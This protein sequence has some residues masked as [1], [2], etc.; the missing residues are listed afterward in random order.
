M[1][2]QALRPRSVRRWLDLWI[3]HSL[4]DRVPTIVYSMERS[5]SVALFDSLQTCGDFAIVTHYLD[6]AKVADGLLSG[7]AVWA[8]RQLIGRGERA[9]VISLVRSPVDNMASTFARFEFGE[10]RS[11]HLTEPGTGSPVGKSNFSEAFRLHYLESGRYLHPLEWFDTEFRVALG[12]DVYERPFDREAGFTK[13]AHGPFEILILRTE[14]TDDVKSRLVSDFLGVD[15]FKMLPP[16]TR[17]GRTPDL[18]PGRPGA[19]SIYG[20]EYKALRETLSVPEE[21]LDRIVASRFARHFF[22]E[23]EL[24]SMKKRFLG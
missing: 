18:A 19:Q 4:R 9:R 8:S 2:F 7:S 13:F 21:Y 11:T 15:G 24:V 14:L 6:P 23:G 10:K 16:T 20:R 22:P 12:V 1:R 5:G 17:V 3:N